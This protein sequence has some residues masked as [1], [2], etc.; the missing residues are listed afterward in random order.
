MND[1]EKEFELSPKY[2]DFCNTTENVDVD[3]LEGTTASGK[4]TVAAG[5]KLM[6]MVSASNKKEHIIL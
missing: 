6:R 3:V 1:K 4:T 5:I 2:I